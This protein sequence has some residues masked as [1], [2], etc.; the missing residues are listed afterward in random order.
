MDA[1]ATAFSEFTRQ[2]LAVGQHRLAE[3][4]RSLVQNAEPAL[5]ERLETATD[6]VFLEPLLFAYF[7]AEEPR[8]PLEQLLFG[9][10]PEVA[11]PDRLRVVADRHGVVELPRIG[12]FLTRRWGDLHLV[13]NG[14]ID[15]CQLADGAGPIG[16]TFR[17]PLI[18]A[19][20]P[21]ELCRYG[22]PLVERFLVDEPGRETCDF[23][24]MSSRHQAQLAA[25]L[26]IIA[27]QHPDYHREILQVT[28]K[29]VLFAG[30]SNSFA[31][32]AA[33]GMAFLNTHPEADEVC[34]L[35][36]LLHQCG[37][38]VFSAITLDASDFLAVD[39]GTPMGRINALDEDARTI[40]E[41]FHGVFTEAHMNRC[42]DLCHQRQVFTGRQAH[43]LVGRLA[44]ILRRSNG[45]LRNLSRPEL[46]TGKGRLLMSWFSQVYN[47]IAQRRSALLG[48]LD[49]SNQPYTFSYAR[50]AELNPQ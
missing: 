7:T 19:G 14:G 40:Y 33:H 16:H 37:H 27:Q 39:A 20:T 15:S 36:D 38:L 24:S 1:I 5:F 3:M 45:D 28:R 41:A 50:F 23:D 43:E 31:A 44:Y 22:H 48:T 18:V 17:E 4:M 26:R 25:A 34:F 32:L 13:W 21:I 42:L 35:E 11:R 9:S 2:Y 49:T 29:I 47:E 10:L 30:R 6:E 8:V 12:F 46:F